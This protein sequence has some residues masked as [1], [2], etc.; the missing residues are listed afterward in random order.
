MSVEHVWQL[1]EIPILGWYIWQYS[2]QL[3]LRYGG[4]RVP[5]LYR[6]IRGMYLFT[7][8][9]DTRLFLQNQS[10]GDEPRGD[11]ALNP[12]FRVLISVLTSHP[13]FNSPLTVLSR[14]V[15]LI[16]DFSLDCIS[17]IISS[18]S[19]ITAQP[20]HTLSLSTHQPNSHRTHETR[21]VRHRHI[22]PFNLAKT[23]LCLLP[24][25]R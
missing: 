14:F 4:T 19:I 13:L 17:Y 20:V 9:R 22:P 1:I 6:T 24:L 11:M 7:G 18:S 10:S 21:L 15:S 8:I 25:S 3:S 23:F 16:L 2:Q 5:K 12:D